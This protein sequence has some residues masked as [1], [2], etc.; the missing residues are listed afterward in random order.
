MSL[1]SSQPTDNK[2]AATAPEPQAR[3][4]RSLSR[5]IVTGVLG[6]VAYLVA[7]FSDQVLRHVIHGW[8]QVLSGL[9][10]T[11]VVAVFAIIGLQEFYTAVR[12]QGAM[13]S[14]G[15]GLIAC[16]IFELVAWHWAGNKLL[17]YVPALLAI[18]LLITFL[19]ELAKKEHK[20]I[21]NIGATL[22]GALY[23]GWLSSFLI[24]LHGLNAPIVRPP[25]F[26]TSRG[27]WLVLFVTAVTWIGDTGGLFTGFWLG[28]HKLAPEISPNK[29]WEGALG[30]IVSAVVMAWLLGRWIDFPLVH[31]LILGV[32][33]GGFGLL[34]DLCESS[35]KRELGVKD[36]GALLPGH[37]GVLDRIDSVLFTAP[38]AYYYVTVIL[39]A[40]R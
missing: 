13:P 23:V 36:F 30:S 12:R 9:P 3:R 31:S 29:T 15:L 35:L 11:V 16:V 5:R 1:S 20:P 10:F 19:V 24:L 21:L 38:L 27:E 7:V 39:L 40:H 2:K 22:L 18:L 17:P 26:G 25:I 28:R 6:A 33:L 8:P 37:G 34:G 32:L 14:D 4:W